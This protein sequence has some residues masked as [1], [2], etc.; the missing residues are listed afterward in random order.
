M[1]PGEGGQL[2][3]ACWGTAV[4]AANP[5]QAGTG[6]SNGAR[7]LCRAVLSRAEPCCAAAQRCAQ[8]EFETGFERG[9]QTREH[10]QLAKT[11]GVTRLVVVVNKLDCPS[12]AVDGE[13][14]GRA[15]QGR[16]LSVSLP[17]WEAQ[18]GLWRSPGG[19]T[20]RRSGPGPG[21]LSHWTLRRGGA[22]GVLGSGARRYLDVSFVRPG[23]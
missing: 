3:L 23:P 19:S 14:E 9:G 13:E 16:G 22:R 1:A 2:K 4:R 5:G 11:L 12:V 8:G 17:W 7:T 20:P 6:G 18:G 21:L 15:G 10:A